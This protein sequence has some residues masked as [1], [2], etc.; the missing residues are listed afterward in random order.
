[1]EDKI[2]KEKVDHYRNLTET[3]LA[4]VKKNIVSGK[5]LEAKE[6]FDMVENYLSDSKHFEEKEDL[7]NC[8]GAIYYAH[9]WIDCGVR[10]GIFDVSDDKLFTIK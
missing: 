2:T 6:I 9:G 5:E 1:M 4:E 8:F 7:V 3:A 10:L